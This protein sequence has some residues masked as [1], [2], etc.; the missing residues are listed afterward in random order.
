[1]SSIEYNSI[2]N[3]NIFLIGIGK[4]YSSYYQ[5]IILE[6]IKN[7]CISS[8]Y[9]DTILEKIKSR[10]YELE[11]IGY[12]DELN[13]NNMRFS[14]KLL[15]LFI[16]KVIFSDYYSVVLDDDGYYTLRIKNENILL[17]LTFK[18]N[19]IHFYLN[20]KKYS[21][22]GDATLEELFNNIDSS[23]Y[24]NFFYAKEGEYVC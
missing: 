15:L 2:C 11:K 23:I 18:N 19:N 24:E 6:K 10:I 13:V 9:Q 3:A 12:E 1:M 17:L 22:S 7:D 14:K 21:K 4:Y 20:S 8:Y 5:D 16:D